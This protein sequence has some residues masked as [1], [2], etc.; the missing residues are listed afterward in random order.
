MRQAEVLSVDPRTGKPAGWAVGAAG[1]AEVDAAVRTAAAAMAPL[2]A[3]DRPALLRAMAAELEADRDAIIAAADAETALGEVRLVG[4]FARTCGQLRFLADVV[5]DGTYLGLVIERAD[6]QAVPPRPDLRRMKVPLGPVAVFAASNFPLAFSV[7]GGD[8]ASALAAGCAVVVKAH[9]G[10]PRTSQ[11]CAAALGRAMPGAVTL[12][13]GWEAGPDLVRHPLIAAVGFTGSV[14]GGRALHDMVAARPSPIPFYGELGSLNPL[15]VTPAAAAQR[16]AAIAAGL[17]A[18]ITGGV[19]QFCTKPGLVLLPEGA[20]DVLAALGDALGAGAG[21]AMLTGSIQEGY[22]RGVA[23][24]GALPGVRTVVEA[25]RGDGFA[26]TPALLTLPAADLAGQHLEEC[27]GPAA[28]CATYRDEADLAAAIDRLPG[29]L[30]ATVHIGQP[31]PLAARLLPRLAALAGRVIVDGYPT[32]VA[33][34]WAMQHGGPYPSSTAPASTS[35]GAAA[36]ER[37]LRPVTYQST[38]DD[39]L[40]PELRE[41]NPLGLPRQVRP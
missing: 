10:H 41:A 30:T 2:A 25:G 6:P 22:L 39:L 9:P 12:L 4:E 28:V 20:A 38:P 5:A 36:I 7:A 11:L 18:S 8:T 37:W 27:F 17:A 13:H 32:G 26:A 23:E 15:I 35:V 21:A 29:S 24:R 34:S 40:P 19:G 1:P 14:A 31:D 16:G 33:V 3:A